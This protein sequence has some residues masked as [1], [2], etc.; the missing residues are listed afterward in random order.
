MRY[1]VGAPGISARVPKLVEPLTPLM[2]AVPEFVMLPLAKGVPRVGRT[3]IPDHVKRDRAGVPPPPWSC[4][5]TPIVIVEAVP[6]VVA[7]DKVSNVRVPAS[8]RVTD[9]VTVAVVSN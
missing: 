6:A 4:V 8:S 3:L 1:A 9:T 5:A 2:A 7:L